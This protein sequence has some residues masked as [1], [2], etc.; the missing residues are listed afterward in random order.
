MTEARKS[1]NIR[2]TETQVSKYRKGGNEK[3]FKE[4]EFRAQVVRAGKTNKELASYLG[5]DESTLYRKIK[6]GGNFTREEINKM[7]IF[8]NIEKPADI[9]FAQELA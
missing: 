8:L 9:F 5:I 7:I 3:M 6:A 4:N 1:D 2:L